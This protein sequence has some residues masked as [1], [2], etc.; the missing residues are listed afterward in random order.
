MIK[1]VLGIFTNPAHVQGLWTHICACVLTGIFKDVFKVWDLIPS[2]Q[3]L[4]P[5]FAQFSSKTQQGHIERKCAEK[6]GI[7]IK[8]WKGPT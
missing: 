4:A 2:S 3:N 7:A 1:N 8:M 6:E 5:G